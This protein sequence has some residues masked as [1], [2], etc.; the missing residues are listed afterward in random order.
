MGSRHV[1]RNEKPRDHI[2]SHKHK[3]ANWKRDKAKTSQSPPPVMSFSCKDVAPPNPNS[4]DTWRPSVQLPE[5][6][7]DISHSKH[8]TTD[9]QYCHLLPCFLWGVC[10]VCL[11]VC[12]HL[13]CGMCMFGGMCTPRLP[14]REQRTTSQQAVLEGSVLF[15]RLAGC[16]LQASGLTG[17]WAGL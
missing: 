9:E 8:Y 16:A 5:P 12:E 2:S 17:C 7:G 1:G 11:C 6:V 14:C 13:T 10:L 3:T 4:T 15:L